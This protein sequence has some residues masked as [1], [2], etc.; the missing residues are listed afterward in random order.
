MYCPC[1]SWTSAAWTLRKLR[2]ESLPSL[3]ANFLA[4]VPLIAS[5]LSRCLLA[6]ASASATFKSAEI[7]VGRR[8]VFAGVQADYLQI[9]A[10]VPGR[11]LKFTLCSRVCAR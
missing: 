3:A 10:I 1:V 2:S 4:A 6:A 8:Y 7:T 9:D 11:R 5:S